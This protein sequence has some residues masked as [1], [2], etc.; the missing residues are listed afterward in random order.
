[1]NIK[2]VLFTTGMLASALHGPAA[3]A[4][5]AGP[6]AEDRFQRSSVPLSTLAIDLGEKPSPP[7]RAAAGPASNAVAVPAVLLSQ[8][9]LPAA[10]P[11]GLE[12]IE[13]NRFWTDTLPGQGFDLKAL[14]QAVFFSMQ[15]QGA[16]AEDALLAAGAALVLGTPSIYVVEDR[17]QLPWFLR[18]ADVSFPHQVK[19][20][21]P[22]QVESELPQAAVALRPEPPLLQGRLPGPA[23]SFIGCLMSGL[24]EEQYQQGGSHLRAIAQSMKD[25]GGV[26]SPFCEGIAVKS[27][28]SFG[29]PAHSLLMDLEAVQNSRHC[30]FYVFDSQ[31]R[32]SG[33]WV[34]LGAALALEKPSVLLTPS[35]EALPPVLRQQPWPENLQVVVYDSHEALMRQLQDPQQAPALVRPTPA[36]IRSAPAG[37]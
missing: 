24:S 30:V 34:E 25:H 11:Q 32:P 37:E 31:S 29:T 27:T 21:A 3:H 22:S 4:E 35:L 28:N 16:R 5:A 13:G 14:R 15:L 2:P 17:K 33:M 7:A 9:P 10:L 18:E 1:M 26:E 12:H 8:Q 19:V 6:V 36:G 20:L 23:D